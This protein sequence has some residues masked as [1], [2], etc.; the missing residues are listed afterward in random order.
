MY[1]EVITLVDE[2]KTVDDYGDMTVTEDTKQVF[3]GVKSVG[4]KE[5]YEAQALGLA[6]EIKIVL[7]DYLDYNGQKVIRYQGFGESSPTDYRVIRT[8]RNGTELEIT[9]TRG[10]ENVSTEVSSQDE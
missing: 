1:N 7:S 4:Q 3:A 2:I 10:I 9:V 8:Y 5:F 6:P